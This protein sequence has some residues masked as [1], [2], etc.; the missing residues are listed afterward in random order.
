V[1]D[2]RSAVQSANCLVLV[3]ATPLDFPSA[4]LSGRCLVL[5]LATPMEPELD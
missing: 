3:L 5:V 4:L 1:S 2:F